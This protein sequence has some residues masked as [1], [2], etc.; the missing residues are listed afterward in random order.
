MCFNVLKNLQ[1]AKNTG[2]FDARLGVALLLALAST[3]SNAAGP[4]FSTL[5]SSI[6]LSTISTAIL[7]IAALLIGPSAVRW[8]AKMIIRFF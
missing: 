1:S 7:A 2:S 6:D 4:D 5:T 3:V 8:G